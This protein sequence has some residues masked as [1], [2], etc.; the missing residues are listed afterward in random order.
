MVKLSNED[1][2]RNF[3]RTF[4]MTTMEPRV[5]QQV[6]NNQR[7]LSVGGVNQEASNSGQFMKL[8]KSESKESKSKTKSVKESDDEDEDYDEQ[9]GEDVLDAEDSWFRLTK[10]DE[11]TFTKR[12][13]DS[14]EKHGHPILSVGLK[15]AKDIYGLH[16]TS[17]G[18]KDRQLYDRYVEKGGPKLDPEDWLKY[19][20]T[21]IDRTAPSS[22]RSELWRTSIF[23]TDNCF[24]VPVFCISK[25]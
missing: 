14:V 25:T 2:Y 21:I 11:K 10:R 6:I 15:F 1:D 9:K 19:K 12:E 24:Q 18:S 3:Y 22:S 23:T 5:K 13:K 8:F 4:E 17:P 16:R 20:P 7:A